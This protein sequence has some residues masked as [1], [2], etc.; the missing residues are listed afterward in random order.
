MN[1]TAFAIGICLGIMLNF[2][3]IYDAIIRR[4]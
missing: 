1:W 4:K 3:K 2:D